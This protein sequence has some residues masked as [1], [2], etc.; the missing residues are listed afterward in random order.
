MICPGGLL[1]GPVDL[2]LPEERAVHEM[3]G[4]FW[5]R[6]PTRAPPN[7]N[8]ADLESGPWLRKA[9]AGIVI[10]MGPPLSSFHVSI[11]F[12]GLWE[13]PRQGSLF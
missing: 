7:L 12:F 9:G 13:L 5:K 8:R 4:P 2:C 11:G 3:C 10:A 1:G 6:N